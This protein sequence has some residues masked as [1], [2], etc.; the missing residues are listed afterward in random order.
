MLD[1]SNNDIDATLLMTNNRI[2]VDAQ[3]RLKSRSKWDDEIDMGFNPTDSFNVDLNDY[4]NND[5]TNAYKE[6]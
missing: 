2:L 6:E 4:S 5:I 3:Q 1:Y